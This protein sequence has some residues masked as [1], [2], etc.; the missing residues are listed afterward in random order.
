MRTD[1]HCLSNAHGLTA[2]LYQRDGEEPTLTRALPPQDGCPMSQGDELQ[3]QG[4]AATQTEGEQGNE[5]EKNSD[6]A[7]DDI[8]VAR[9]SLESDPFRWNQNPD[10]TFCLS[11][12]FSENRFPLF[13][14]ML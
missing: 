3:P 4:G 10:L 7:R 9:K 1:Q 5:G 8:A 12:I 14:I 13:G 11:M 2:F 6:H